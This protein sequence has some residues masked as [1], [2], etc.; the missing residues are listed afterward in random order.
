MSNAPPE[1]YSAASA[2][3]VRLATTGQYT[4]PDQ[5]LLET[6]LAI[7]RELGDPEEGRQ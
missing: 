7:T 1:L 4:F 5:A 2:D 6:I 3:D